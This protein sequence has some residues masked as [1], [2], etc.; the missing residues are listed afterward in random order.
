MSMLGNG[1]NVEIRNIEDGNFTCQ[2]DV[3]NAAT[4][5][6]LD[7]ECLRVE[8]RGSLFAV[9]RALFAMIHLDNGF[10]ADGGRQKRTVEG[11]LISILE[12]E[13]MRN[14]E[15]FGAGLHKLIKK[16]SG[17]E[18]PEVVRRKFVD[19]VN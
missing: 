7:R 10:A 8:A 16:K 13:D 17:D 11:V 12:T 4:S 19:D 6:V 18:L 5:A 2:V 9:L 15:Q 1:L 14:M 3:T